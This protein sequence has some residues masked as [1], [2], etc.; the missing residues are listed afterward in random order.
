[1]KQET[2][3]RFKAIQHNLVAEFE[4]PEDIADILAVLEAA[5]AYAEAEERSLAQYEGE[6][7]PPLDDRIAAN[8]ARNKAHDAL[9]A[10]I[11]LG[12]TE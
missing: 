7:V 11:D 4:Q 1:M 6:T 9:L 2:I 10:L 5:Q 12:G 3:E 8:R